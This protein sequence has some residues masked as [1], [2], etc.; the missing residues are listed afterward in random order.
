MLKAKIKMPKKPVRLSLNQLPKEDEIEDSDKIS[1]DQLN[2]AKLYTSRE[3][4]IKTL[5][6]NIDYM[7][8]GVAWGYY[9]KLVADWCNPKS[10]DLVDWYNQDLKCWSW[11]KFG[12]CQ[13]NPKHVLEYEA[14]NHE[15]YIKDKFAQYN[16]VK[17]IK[18][19]AREVLNGVEK[20][21]DYIYIDITNNRHITKTV[22]NLCSTLVDVGGIIGLNDYLIYDG[23]IEDMPYG[24][25]QTVN[26]FLSLNKNW[27]VDGIALHNLGFYDIYIRKSA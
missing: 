11:R 3:E 7:E 22:L 1:Q 6:N 14:E 17:T 2:T 10:I 9:S 13:C 26:E 12:E 8:V 20:K 23:I 24:T 16:N 25:F 19:D 15:Q 5:K 4:Y 18:G 27:V 21:Y